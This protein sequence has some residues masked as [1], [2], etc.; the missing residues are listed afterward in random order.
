L[1]VC[2]ANGEGMKQN[3]EKT[4]EQGHDDSQKALGICYHNGRGVEKNH[5]KAV[6]WL[7]KSSEQGHEEA[8]DILEF[9]QSLHS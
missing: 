8:K 3:Y 4:A 7:T 5:E 2:Y 9:I 6:E 1:G